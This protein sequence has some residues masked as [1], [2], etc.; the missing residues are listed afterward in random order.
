MLKV[1]YEKS[2]LNKIRKIKDSGLKNRIIKQ[3]EKII[4]DPSVGKPMKYARKGTRELY[5]SSYRIAYAYILKE[6]RIVFLNIYH[7]DEQ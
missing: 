1:S 4:E 3:V 5:I 7:K 6:E 2:F